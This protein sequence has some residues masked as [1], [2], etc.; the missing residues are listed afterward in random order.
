MSHKVVQPKRANF[1]CP[2]SYTPQS[3]PMPPPGPHQPRDFVYPGWPCVR[4][5][6]LLA[7]SL[8]YSP[9]NCGTFALCRGKFTKQN[10]LFFLF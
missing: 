5:L 8:V 10:M 4:L 9:K 1:R 3:A 7:P 6:A 2:L